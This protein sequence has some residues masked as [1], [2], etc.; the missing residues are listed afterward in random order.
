MAS[1]FP[2]FMVC[3]ENKKG[4][5]GFLCHPPLS[6]IPDLLGGFTSQVPDVL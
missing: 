3:S 6:E 2:W 1:S 4:E 5:D